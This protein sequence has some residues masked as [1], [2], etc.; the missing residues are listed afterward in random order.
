MKNQH[1]WE[2]LWV[3]GE[4]IHD[5]GYDLEVRY[6]AERDEGMGEYEVRWYNPVPGGAYRFVI[7][8]RQGHPTLISQ[9]FFYKGFPAV[10]P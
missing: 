7:E 5:D 8:P 3:N 1:R 10:V 6:L 9:E 4:P 2:T